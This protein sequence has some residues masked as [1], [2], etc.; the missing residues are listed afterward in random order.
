MTEAE[1]QWGAFVLASIGL[2]GLVILWLAAV[3]VVWLVDRS[4]RKRKDLNL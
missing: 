3:L 2:G 1:R 4:G